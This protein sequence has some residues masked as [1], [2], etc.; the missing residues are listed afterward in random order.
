MINHFGLSHQNS[1]F[2]VD[3]FVPSDPDSRHLL[4]DPLPPELLQAVDLQLRIPE[5]NCF[6]TLS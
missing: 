4:Q 6:V 1:E 5:R 2:I 3:G